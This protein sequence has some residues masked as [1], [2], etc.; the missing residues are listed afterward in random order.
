MNQEI[1]LTHLNRRT[2]VGTTS[3]LALSAGTIASAQEQEESQKANTKPPIVIFS[4]HLQWLDYEGLAE[5][6]AELGFD[7][8]DLT[9]RPG[10][11]V[12][13]ENVKR[14]LPKATEAI[15]KAGLDVHMIT[16][17]IANPGDINTQYILKTASELGIKKYRIG[18][19]RYDMDK[20][21]MPQ[22]GEW[23]KK[24][25]SLAAMNKNYGMVSGYHNHSGRGYIGGA[26]WDI[27]QMMRTIP[28]EHM[29][30]NYDIGHAVSEGSN[31]S[32]EIDF[33]I[34]KKRI[35][36][37]AVK[38]FGWFQDENGN[39][40]HKFVPMG[41]GIVPWQRALK[42]MKEIGFEGPF[43]IHFEYHIEGESEE[44]RQQNELIAYK[45]DLDFFRKQVDAV[46]GA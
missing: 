20:D 39:W 33:E 34:V 13:P 11:H 37:S 19:Y 24:L 22:L 14:D 41:E 23:N 7:G 28:F 18:S 12:L 10:G 25:K 35:H 21:I 5:K 1:N 45:K 43:S 16:T 15:R 29:G 26:I 36:M 2:F 3:T 38:D 32:W 9:V 31:G 4:K 27:H 30:C 6:T 42:K 44:E 40:D 17:R 8:V 46:W